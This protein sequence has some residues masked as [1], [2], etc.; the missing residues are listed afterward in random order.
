MG[1]G[2]QRKDSKTFGTL[3]HP[4]NARPYLT[5]GTRKLSRQIIPSLM[6]VNMSVTITNFLTL[7]LV[8][9]SLWN[10]I[11]EDE[12]VPQ[13]FSIVTFVY[14]VLIYLRPWSSKA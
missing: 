5:F 11:Y 3:T 6:G 10:S 1:L 2:P 12:L 14:Y 9:P 4:S 8:E 13:L 7:Q